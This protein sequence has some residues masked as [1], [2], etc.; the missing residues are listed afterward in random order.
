M[1]R[2][3]EL[4]R[5]PGAPAVDGPVQIVRSAYGRGQDRPVAICGDQATISERE[6]M[7]NYYVDAMPGDDNLGQ[8]ATIAFSRPP[9]A[10][11]DNTAPPTSSERQVRAP[12]WV[13]HDPGPNAQPS[14]GSAKRTVLTD[15]GAPVERTS[16]AVKVG[17]GAGTPTQCVPESVVRRTE[18]HGGEAHERAVPNTYPSVGDTKVTEDG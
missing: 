10:A 6:R 11:R 8:F 1:V 12:S 17:R 3:V 4:L 9:T 2:G 5:R 16:G 14:N 13:T 7:A 15:V 18:V